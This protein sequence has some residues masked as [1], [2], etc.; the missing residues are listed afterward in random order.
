MSRFSSTATGFSPSPRSRSSIETVGAGVRYGSPFK[1]TSTFPAFPV[2]AD[3]MAPPPSGTDRSGSAPFSGK[4]YMCPTSAGRRETRPCGFPALEFSRTTLPPNPT[5]SPKAPVPLDHPINRVDQ[6]LLRHR[7]DD[8]LLERAV[9]EENEIGNTANVVTHCGFLVVIDVYLHHL[10]L[11]AVLRGE[12]VDDGGDGLA[13]SAP[14]S[15]EVDQ[16]RHRGLQ[17]VFFKAVVTHF[18]NF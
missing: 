10:Q 14:R 15:P 8:L 13:R 4:N 16:H 5:R 2:R 18:Q 12:L 1:R 6:I 17:D 11:L 3:S 7:S 9:F